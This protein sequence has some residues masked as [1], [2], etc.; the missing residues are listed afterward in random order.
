MLQV[1]KQYRPDNVAIEPAL[2]KIVEYRNK[3]EERQ[4]EINNISTTSIEINDYPTSVRN[5]IQNK[6][7]LQSVYEL[8]GCKI[9]IKGLYFESGKKIP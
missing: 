6:E 7:Y 5:K 3:F 1:I 9:T 2:R 8:T 4:N